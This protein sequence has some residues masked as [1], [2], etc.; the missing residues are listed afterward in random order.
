M[1]GR[2]H[3]ASLLQEIMMAE[4]FPSC[5]LCFGEGKILCKRHGRFL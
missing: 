1:A 2:T 5:S 4:L 3:V